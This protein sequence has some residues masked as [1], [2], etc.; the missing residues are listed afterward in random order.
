VHPIFKRH[1]ET[2]EYWKEL[3]KKMNNYYAIKDEL[4]TT[5]RED[6]NIMLLKKR[7][8]NSFYCYLKYTVCPNSD[9]FFRTKG[10]VAKYAE[11][12][13]PLIMSRH[14]DEK[15][16]HL[17][18]DLDRAV[19]EILDKKLYINSESEL[20]KIV[21]RLFELV[22]LS[23]HG[24]GFEFVKKFQEQQS[25]KRDK[26]G[27]VYSIEPDG[28]KKVL[29]TKEEHDKQIAETKRLFNIKSSVEALKRYS[30]KHDSKNQ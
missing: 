3:R 22:G 29:F 15:Q 27:P 11:R 8:F 13:L 23:S 20:F 14:R 16:R 26:R 5:N 9:S 21:G 2:W 6:P 10:F 17:M 18:P 28:T 1:I 30:K 19:G 25:R 7:A 4:K 24:K 12:N